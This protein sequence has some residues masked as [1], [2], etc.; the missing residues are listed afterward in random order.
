MQGRYADLPQHGV[1]LLLR[2]HTSVRWTSAR[3]HWG[4]RGSQGRRPGADGRAWADRMARPIDP[5]R[6]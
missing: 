5:R 6:T 4:R 3:P 1:I 2:A